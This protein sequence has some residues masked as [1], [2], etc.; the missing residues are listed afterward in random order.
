ME[1]SI[2]NPDVS[3]VLKEKCYRYSSKHV[4]EHRF[5]CLQKALDVYM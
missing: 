5:I 4:V 3:M 1:N 2:K